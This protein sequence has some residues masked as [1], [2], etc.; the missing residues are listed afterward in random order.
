[1]G[2][3]EL[4]TEFKLASSGLETCELGKQIMDYHL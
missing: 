3:P 1:M 2:W 4:T